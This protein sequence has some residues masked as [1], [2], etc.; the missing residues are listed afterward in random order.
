MGVGRV[1]YVRLFTKTVQNKFLFLNPDLGANNT[2]NSLPQYCPPLDECQMTRLSSETCTLQGKNIGMGPFEPIIC[3]AG[4]YCPPSEN[5]TTTISCPS[6]SYCQPGASTPTPCASGSH[7][8][9]GS[10]YQVYLVPLVLLII[11]DVLSMAGYL[12]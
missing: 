7:C 6:G 10:S 1:S 2:A 5:G 9:E 8:P 3:Q 4:N 12:F 11:V